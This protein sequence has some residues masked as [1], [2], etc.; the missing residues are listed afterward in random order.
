[1]LKCCLFSRKQLCSIFLKSS[2]SGKREREGERNGDR[3]A[4]WSAGNIKC[5]T[6]ECHVCEIDKG[7]KEEEEKERAREMGLRKTGRES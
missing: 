1:M 4:F 6:P 5:S 2:L 7:E 3:G